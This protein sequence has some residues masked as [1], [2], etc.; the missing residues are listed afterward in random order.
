MNMEAAL[1]L[2]RSKN[3]DPYETHPL[4]AA[5]YKH[6]AWAKMQQ[7]QF[8]E[9]EQKFRTTLEILSKE[10]NQDRSECKVDQLHAK[11][12]LAMIHRFQGADAE[13][14]RAYAQLTREISEE[15]LRL[16]QSSNG[17][18]YLA[19]V[20]ALLYDRL[21]NSLERQADCYL[22]G[23]R[24]DFEAAAFY[25]RRGLQL[26]GHVPGNRR[27]A[28]QCDLLYRQAIALFLQ[29]C[30]C[31]DPNAAEHSARDFLREQARRILGSALKLHL[32]S[33][34][35][36]VSVQLDRAI[37]EFLSRTAE[38]DGSRHAVAEARG[39]DR[40]DPPGAEDAGTAP[41]NGGGAPEV[42]LGALLDELRDSKRDFDRDELERMMFA[43]RL[44]ILQP[45]GKLNRFKRLDLAEQL[46]AHCRSALRLAYADP[47]VLAY[48]R[49]YFD[50]VFEVKTQ[51]QPVGTKELIELVWEATTGD[52]NPP[53]LANQPVLAMYFLDDRC[54]L[55]L[56]VPH[57]R[58]DRFEIDPEELNSVNL[59]R[60]AS[61]SGRVFPCPDGLRKRLRAIKLPQ[62]QKL[63]VHYRDPV[64][65]L[66][67]THYVS[68]K[69]PEYES[70]DP[71]SASY[72]FPFDIRSALADP[73]FEIET[74]KISEASTQADTAKDAATGPTT[75]SSRTSSNE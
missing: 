64:H 40:T 56:D 18:A 16:E 23:R 10:E 37:A 65:K 74:I 71:A 69:P 24:P 15:I 29:S 6:Y 51:Y 7:W 59:I 38:A 32:T 2:L 3:F 68:Q 30:D 26:A 54:H 50:A 66:G 44:L 73:S 43:Y 52:L 21:V 72:L 25:Y 4:T 17:D 47:G 67:E 39:G 34:K 61:K 42:V 57:G 20:R 8:G 58:S 53:P 60:Q 63:L 12:G 27:A 45:K 13:A 33:D 62:G 75:A 22:F 11:H 36:P 48:L 31:E 49:P 5:A 28:I 9:A 35:P 19:E 41:S 14:I 1:E 55:V 46:H 70:S